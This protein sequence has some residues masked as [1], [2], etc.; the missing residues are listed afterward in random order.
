MVKVLRKQNFLIWTYAVCVQD[1]YYLFGL[2]FN[3]PV[4][5]YGHVEMLNWPNQTFSKASLD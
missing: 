3:V 1:T 5:S 4:K 2:L